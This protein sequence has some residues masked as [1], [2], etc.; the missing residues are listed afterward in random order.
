MFTFRNEL[1]AKFAPPLD[2]SGLWE[3]F[4]RVFDKMP[5]ACIVND[6]IWVAHGG[7]PKS[8]NKLEVKRA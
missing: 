1:L 2:G 8:T 6:V 7:V 5:I 4:N 3:T